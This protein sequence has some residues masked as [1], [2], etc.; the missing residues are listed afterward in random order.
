[1][2]KIV[3]IGSLL[4]WQPPNLGGGGRI[5]PR[6]GAAVVLA[7]RNIRRGPQSFD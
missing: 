7:F 4:L 3:V 1:V 2:L 6:L 5:A